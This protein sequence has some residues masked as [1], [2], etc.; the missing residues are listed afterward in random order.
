MIPMM[1]SE[2]L[3]LTMGSAPNNLPPKTKMKIQA[4]PPNTL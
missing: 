4:T 3:F 1:M 2:K